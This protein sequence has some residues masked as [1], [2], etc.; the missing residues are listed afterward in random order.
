MINGIIRLQIIS[1][2]KLSW[3]FKRNYEWER[4]KNLLKIRKFYQNL[5][6]FLKVI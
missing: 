1:K 5:V 3:N 6:D 4:T 2:M